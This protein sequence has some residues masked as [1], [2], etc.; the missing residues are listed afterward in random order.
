MILDKEIV[1]KKGHIIRGR[2]NDNDAYRSRVQI[3]NMPQIYA[4]G[5]ES[6]WSKTPT[7]NWED[8]NL[9][10]IPLSYKVGDTVVDYYS[11]SPAGQNIAGFDLFNYSRV[12]TVAEASVAAPTV[13]EIYTSNK[14]SQWYW[15]CR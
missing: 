1:L 7:S 3:N 15:D 12:S 2:L 10:T 8:V 4:W 9:V 13:D 11:G 6:D 5:H 14:K